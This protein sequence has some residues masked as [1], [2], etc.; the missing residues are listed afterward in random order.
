M[1]HIKLIFSDILKSR[2]KFFPCSLY[3]LKVTI[4][5]TDEYLKHR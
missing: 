1:F 4:T 3:K 5:I 2:V